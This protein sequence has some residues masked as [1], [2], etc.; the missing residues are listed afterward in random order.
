MKN[1]SKKNIFLNSCL[2]AIGLILYGIGTYLTIRSG[3]GISPW[4]TLADGLARTIGITFGTAS[5]A[6]SLILLI[7][8]VI[9]K[10]RI[11]I[12]M[13]L[14]SFLVGIT[15]DVCEAIG[16]FRT[17]SNVLIGI[18]ILLLGVFVQ[19]FSQFVYMKAALGCGPRDSFLLGLSRRVTRFP[20]G[21]V[22]IFIMV[23]VAA[24]GIMLGGKI[25]IGTAICAFLTGPIMQLIFRLMRFDAESVTHQDIITS[26]KVIV[27]AGKRVN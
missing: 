3:L 16:F 7:T 18:S 13:F 26:F 21:A 25:G 17:P 15:V 19:G 1:D 10:E 24:L 4:D 5:I 22:S 8:D 12:G 11:G 9:L 14:D 27:A 6:I 20:I 23:S 2:A